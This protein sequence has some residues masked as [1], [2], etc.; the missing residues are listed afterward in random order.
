MASKPET[1]GRG[2]R[3]GAQVSPAKRR[4][5]KRAATRARRR[6]ERLDPEQA[7]DRVRRG[8]AS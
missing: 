2:S 3:N 8:W 5:V 6:A 1:I 4:E 7:P